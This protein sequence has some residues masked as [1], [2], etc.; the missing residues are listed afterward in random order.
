MGSGKF[1]SSSTSSRSAPE[2]NYVAAL[3]WAAR[4]CSSSMASRRSVLIPSVSDVRPMRWSYAD[5]IG[6]R[7]VSWLRHPNGEPH[8]EYSASPMP[9]VRRA[10]NQMELHHLDLW[11][12]SEGG[13]TPLFVD[14]EGQI[15]IR[16][17]EGDVRATGQTALDVL[18]SLAPFSPESS[19]GPD[20]VR[21]RPTSVSSRARSQESL[22]SAGFTL[23]HRD[24]RRAGRTGATTPMR[25]CGCTPR[26]IPRRS[27]PTRRSSRPGRPTEQP[28]GLPRSNRRARS[29]RRSVGQS[30]LRQ[31]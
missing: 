3:T 8:P 11:S 21:P 31:R 13:R 19:R 1:W 26:R 17:S 6:L 25:S 14:Q 15:T 9:E 16:T 24:H 23:N 27:A 30:A 18:D 2:L 4:A 7:I 28:H 12:E 5:L 29:R 10:L 22:S 20:L